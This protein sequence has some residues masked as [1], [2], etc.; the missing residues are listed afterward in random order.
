LN[1]EVDED[2]ERPLY[3]TTS[4]LLF[5]VGK[6]TNDRTIFPLMGRPNEVAGSKETSK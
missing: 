5:V 1:G 3:P 4:I 6:N 2:G